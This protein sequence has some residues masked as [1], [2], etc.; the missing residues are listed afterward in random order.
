MGRVCPPFYG[1]ETVM[2][3]I[4]KISKIDEKINALAIE[5]EEYVADLK[6][7]IKE[8]TTA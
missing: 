6:K 8:S 7:E 2:N 3:L 1:K 4:D 5:R